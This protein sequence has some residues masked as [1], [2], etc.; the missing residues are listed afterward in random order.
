MRG[1]GFVWHVTPF[2][3]RASVHGVLGPG[4]LVL[5]PGYLPGMTQA[6]ANRTAK[7]VSLRQK[8]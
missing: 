4:Y 7:A 2:P 6:D 8:V 5:G 3:E 1:A